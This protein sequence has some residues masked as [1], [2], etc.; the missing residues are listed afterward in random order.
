MIKKNLLGGKGSIFELISP[1]AYG[2]VTV[3]N[4]L[5]PRELLVCFS[6]SAMSSL[7]GISMFHVSMF[8]FYKVLVVRRLHFHHQIC[9]HKIMRSLSLFSFCAI[10]I[11]FLIYSKCQVNVLTFTEILIIVTVGLLSVNNWSLISQYLQSVFY[12][13]IKIA[14]RFYFV[15][16]VEVDVLG[17]LKVF[18]KDN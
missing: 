12:L 3:I 7:M 11:I 6:L 17:L 2:I 13:F 1:I 18:S 9:Y 10:I 8:L 14:C 4:F 5:K 15:K 16:K